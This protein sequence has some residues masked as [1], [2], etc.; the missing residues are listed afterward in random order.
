MYF[1]KS[2]LASSIMLAISGTALAADWE[3]PKLE[4]NGSNQT[5]MESAYTK[6]VYNS[7][8]LPSGLE[9]LQD[10]SLPQI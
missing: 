2:I 3:A 5:E 4:F 6:F 7:A 8:G 9:E 1:T 10:I